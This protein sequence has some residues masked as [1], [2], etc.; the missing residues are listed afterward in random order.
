MAA[1]FPGTGDQGWLAFGALVPLLV[2]IEG[3]TLR[4]AAMLGLVGGLVFW[5]VTIPWVAGTMVRYRGLP[6]PL[7]GLIL[8][9]LVDTLPS[10][11]RLSAPCFP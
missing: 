9:G 7:G 11:G 1:T 6:W 8:L 5:L 10:T 4:R 3:A 2:V